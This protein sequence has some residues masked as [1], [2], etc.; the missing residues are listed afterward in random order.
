MLMNKKTLVDELLLDRKKFISETQLLDEV[1]VILEN[2]ELERQE[3]KEKLKS[4]SSTNVNKF[5]FDLLETD[6]IFHIN[7]IKKVS[8]DYRLRF[9]DS[10]L[11]K[12][13]IPE[14]AITKISDLE[15]SHNTKL[16]GFKIIAPSKAFQLINYDDP[17]LFAPI[18]NDYYYLIHKWGNDLVWYRKL[19]VLPFKNLKNFVYFCGIISAIIIAVSPMD[20]LSKDVPMAPIIL[21][22]FMFKGVIAS[23]SYYFFLMGKNFNSEIWD[24]K[25]KE[26]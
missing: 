9:L 24:R 7:Q 14:E 8:I 26:N 25:F 20:D 10:S 1:R 12:N 15:K 6:K 5:E 2:N 18:G 4:K 22:L 19:M 21:F 13:E 23:I 11:F 3:I 16:E 17:L